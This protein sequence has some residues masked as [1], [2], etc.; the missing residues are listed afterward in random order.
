MKLPNG[1]EINCELDFENKIENLNPE[2]LQ[3][4]TA[5][6]VYKHSL[7]LG[8]MEM[9]QI[10]ID[11][12]LQSIET[13][14][15]TRNDCEVKQSETSLRKTKKDTLKYVGLGGLGTTGLGAVI[16]GIVELVRILHG[17]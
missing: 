16:Y 12:R 2:G 4:W 3:K 15:K 7:Q 9:R 1:D 11:S 8:G 13:I 5:R 6:E 10:G 17:G 14:C